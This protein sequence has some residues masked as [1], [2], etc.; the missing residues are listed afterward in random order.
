MGPDITLL[1]KSIAESAVNTLYL[2]R[3]ID[4][5]LVHLVDYLNPVRQS[6]TRKPG[7]GTAYQTYLRTA[8]L[9]ANSFVDVIDLD[10]VTELPEK[11]GSYTELT[12]PYKTVGSRG[13]IY[14]RVQ[15]TGR[16]V[17]DL[18]REEVEGKAREVADAEEHRIFWGNSPSANTLQFPGIHSYMA[19]NTGQIV[20]L[21]NTGTGVTLTLSALDQAIDLN[22]GNPGLIVTSRRGRRKL[23]ALLQAQQRWVDSVEIAAGF[24]VMTYNGIPVVPSTHIPNTIDINASGVVTSLTGGSSTAFFVL[25]VDPNVLFMSVL[26]EVTMMPLARVSSVYEEF[27]L[28]MDETLVLKDYRKA[29]MLTGVAATSG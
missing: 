22:L 10:D 5:V 20:A 29:S 21:T 18:M 17:A 14:R 11:T 6:I 15:K 26:T 9:T 25:D 12:L 24:K 16:T 4:R 19:S 23:N 7:S 2:E 28:Y 27:D 3:E 13:R 8:G 1:R